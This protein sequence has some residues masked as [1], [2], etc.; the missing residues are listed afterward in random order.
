MV[1]EN[2]NKNRKCRLDNIP[3]LSEQ[4]K[5]TVCRRHKDAKR[6]VLHVI[7]ISL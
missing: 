2:I 6:D 3:Q 7:S 1:R 5:I 4:G